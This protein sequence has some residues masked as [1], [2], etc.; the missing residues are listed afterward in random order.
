MAYICL[1]IVLPFKRFN[2]HWQ[3]IFLLNYKSPYCQKLLSCKTFCFNPRNICLVLLLKYL[4]YNTFAYLLPVIINEK[5]L[6]TLIGLVL[7]REE[8]P[9]FIELVSKD[10]QTRTLVNASH[11][12]YTLVK[13]YT[14]DRRCRGF[15]NSSVFACK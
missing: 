3:R 5:N 9:V 14:W 6:S 8:N 15:G 1:S 4:L 12:T 10:G 13:V 2:L 7:Y 11:T